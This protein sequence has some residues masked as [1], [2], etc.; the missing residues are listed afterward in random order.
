MTELK[1]LKDF[2]WGFL[3]TDKKGKIVI[4]KRTEYSEKAIKFLDLRKEAIKWIMAF[5][6]SGSST[7]FIKG[8]AAGLQTFFNINEE[9]L[10]NG[11]RES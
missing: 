8:Q 9:D 4:G 5:R 1:T 10:K 7:F 3:N 6:N 2:D 11:K